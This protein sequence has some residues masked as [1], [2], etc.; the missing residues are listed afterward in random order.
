MAPDLA[1]LRDVASGALLVLMLHG[2]WIPGCA[3]G[4]SGGYPSTPRGPATAKRGKE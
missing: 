2:P 1:A 3:A 4:L